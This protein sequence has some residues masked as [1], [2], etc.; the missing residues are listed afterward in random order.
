LPLKGSIHYTIVMEW[1]ISAPDGSGFETVAV[2]GE[3]DLYSAP[4][5]AKAMIEKV[6]GGSPRLRVDL[7]EVGYLDSTGVGALIRIIQAARATGCDLRFRG[8]GGS[9]R[10]VLKMSNIIPLMRE[11]KD[12]R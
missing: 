3:C 7:S 8:I 2:K 6:K 12:D 4:A 9:P 1:R 11:D 10:K 5:F